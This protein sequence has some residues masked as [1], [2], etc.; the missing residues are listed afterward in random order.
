MAKKP[1]EK[2]FGKQTVASTKEVKNLS[3]MVQQLTDNWDNLTDSQKQSIN[4]V[5]DY[6]DG[7]S[8]SQKYSEKNLNYAKEIANTG[9][10]T[11]KGNRLLNALNR[12]RLKFNQ[13]IKGH[14]NDIAVNI[15]EQRE[16]N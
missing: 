6:S 3:K 8:K 15:A 4:L 2:L 13:Q 12:N 1:N 5:K 9:M 14:S 16:R 11:I 7:L 10:I